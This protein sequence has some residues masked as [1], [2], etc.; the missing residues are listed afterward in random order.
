MKSGIWESHGESHR[1]AFIKISQEFY[2]ETHIKSHGDSHIRS[3]TESS[4]ESHMEIQH[5]SL[6][7]ISHEIMLQIS[8]Q[9]PQS[10]WLAAPHPIPNSKFLPST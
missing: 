4:F 1:V 6:H 2:M 9:I 8:H 7:E 3:C 10:D 5:E